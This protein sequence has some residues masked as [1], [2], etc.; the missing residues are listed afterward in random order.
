MLCIEEDGISVVFF[1]TLKSITGVSG[2][3]CP[4]EISEHSKTPVFVV[5]TV[6]GNADRSTDVKI[7]P[8][9]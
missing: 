5:G 3:L 8:Q 7:H 2:H 9:T 6:K 4:A 1:L